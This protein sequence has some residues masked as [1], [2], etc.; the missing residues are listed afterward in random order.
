MKQQ[1]EAKDPSEKNEETMDGERKNNNVSCH[2]LIIHCRDLQ[3]NTLQGTKAV[4]LT[5]HKNLF[6][7]L[8]VFC[9]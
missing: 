1:T 6:T 2:Y 8:I 9:D 3:K 5:S 7:F 4:S